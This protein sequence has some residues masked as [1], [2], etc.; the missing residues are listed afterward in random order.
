MLDALGRPRHPLRRDLALVAPS[1][2]S[3]T[4]ISAG[5][6]R[7]HLVILNAISAGDADGGARGH[8]RPSL[9]PASSATA[10]ACTAAAGLSADFG[11]PQPTENSRAVTAMSQTTPTTHRAAPSTRLPPRRWAPRSCAHNFHIEDLFQPGRISLTYTHYDRMIVGGAVPADDAAAARGDQADRHQ[12]LPRPPRADRRQ[13]RRRRHAST[14]GGETYRLGTRD[15]L[16]LGMGAADGDV[17][18]GRRGEPGEV[19]P[20]QRAGASEPI[21]AG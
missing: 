6:Q 21:R 14:V 18:L 10:S 20:A 15:M 16:Y 7:E 4:T 8:A 1:V 5:L 3:P 11:K 19:L 17:R 13:H 12:E 2:L 9:A